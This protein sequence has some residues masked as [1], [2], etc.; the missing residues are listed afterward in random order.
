[1]TY[2]MSF[3]GLGLLAAGAIPAGSRVR[4]D[5]SYFPFCPRRKAVEGGT[6]PLTR[7]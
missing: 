3:S 2:D 6:I 1:M 4:I 7:R 5:A